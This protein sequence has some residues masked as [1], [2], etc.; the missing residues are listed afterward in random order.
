MPDQLHAWHASAIAIDI[1]PDEIGHTEVVSA[2]TDRSAAP[3]ERPSGGLLSPAADRSTET[4]RLVPSPSLLGMAASAAK[5][6][7]KFAASGFKTVAP[8]T[9][10]LRVQQCAECQYHGGS[11][12]SVC[13]CFFDKKAWLPHEDCP[14]GKWAV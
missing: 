13:G 14:I 4:D 9:H 3:T 11:R 8:E 6:A 5:S 2:R 1:D 7:A 12:C 10:R